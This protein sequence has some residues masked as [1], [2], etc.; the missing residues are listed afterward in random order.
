MGTALMARDA[1][2][3]VPAEVRQIIDDDGASAWLRAALWS[4]LLR[5]PVDALNDAD[6]LRAAIESW[7][8]EVLRASGVTPP[9]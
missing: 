8:A 1:L 3:G 5:D 4:A 7:T 6:A 9:Q 2:D